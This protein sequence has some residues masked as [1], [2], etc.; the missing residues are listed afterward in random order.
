MGVHRIDIERLDLARLPMSK[1]QPVKS[2]RIENWGQIILLCIRMHLNRVGVQALAFRL[3]NPTCP[4]QHSPW[5]IPLSAVHSAI[6]SQEIGFSHLW[7]AMRT[8]NLST[9]GNGVFLSI[10]N[11]HSRL[12]G[13]SFNRQVSDPTGSVPRSKI[14]YS[15]IKTVNIQQLAIRPD[16][17]NS[18]FFKKF[19]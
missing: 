9:G 14:A 7:G 13:P 3:S 17:S 15:P 16:D 18:S 19:W 11:A 12:S 4:S 5:R 6:Q 10:D 8:N 2:K 1:T